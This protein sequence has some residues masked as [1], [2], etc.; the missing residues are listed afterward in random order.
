MDRKRPR[1][2]R[3]MGECGSESL[4]I[5]TDF[6]SP[7]PTYRKKIK[8]K[9][10]ITKFRFFSFIFLNTSVQSLASSANVSKLLVKSR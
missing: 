10:A 2:N 7:G 3:E 6:L 8:N 9:T 1:N 5:I 4:V